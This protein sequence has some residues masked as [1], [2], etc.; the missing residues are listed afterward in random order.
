[1]VLR[2]IG[3]ITQVCI[4]HYAE[5]LELAAG[6]HCYP[7]PHEVLRLEMTSGYKMK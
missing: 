5:A 1:M 4:E 3:G 7:I 6:P 2:T